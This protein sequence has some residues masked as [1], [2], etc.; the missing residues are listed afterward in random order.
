[1]TK[2]VLLQ[3]RGT[4]SNFTRSKS[5]YPPLGLCQIAA[6]LNEEDVVIIDADAL[7]LTT[8]ETII[9]IKKKSPKVIGM[10]ATS[11]NLDTINEWSS[12]AF[13]NNIDVIVGGPHATIYPM[14]IFKKCHGVNYVVRGEGD[15]IIT[16]LL[17]DILTKQTR[18]LDGVCYRIGNDIFI[19]EE[20]IRIDDLSAIPLA[21]FRG[22]PIKNYWCPDAKRKPMITVQLSRG[23]PNNC[24][25]CSSTFF[26]GRRIRYHNF[27]D[28]IN[29]LEYVNKDLGVKELSFVDDS[30]TANKKMAIKICEGIIERNLDVTWFC[31]IRADMITDELAKIMKKA[32]CH[33]AYIGF[34]S[35]N[36]DMLNSVNKG[37]KLKDYY[38]GS[39][40]LSENGINISAGF[41]VGLPGET[42]QTVDDSIRLANEIKPYRIQF[43][44]FTPLPGSALQDYKSELHVTFHEKKTDIVGLWMEKAYQRCGNGIWGLESL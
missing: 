14:D 11:F 22:L 13:D 34:E 12:W 8:E 27:E 32:G 21:S 40:I 28:I 38:E 6:N 3:P 19:S 43:T 25:F 16:E 15:L 29:H 37:T 9:E 31:N 35:G 30:F 41:I 26:Q 4:S 18:K 42:E 1:M 33:Q 17:E 2:L 36:Q 24:S 39:R 7:N 23:C 10:T 20:I 44:R 5:L